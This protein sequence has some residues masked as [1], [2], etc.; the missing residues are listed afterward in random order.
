MRNLFSLF[1]IVFTI[2]V[3]TAQE[4]ETRQ[5]GNF[6]GIKV[7]G[8]M[9]VVLEK[10][11]KEEVL[12]ESKVVPL[13]RIITK[14]DKNGVLKIYKK[15]AN[16]Y[17]SIKYRE[18]VRS[19]GNINV[20]ITYKNLDNIT[21]S[22]SGFIIV[23]SKLT[24]ENFSISE[25]GSGKI[26]VKNVDL[27]QANITVSGSGKVEMKE[28]SIKEQRIRVSGSGKVSLLGVSAENSFSK[29]SGSGKIY[30]NVSQSF[31]GQVSGSGDILYSGNPAKIISKVSG[32][33][34]IRKTNK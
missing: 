6:K 14:I 34:K 3:S 1:I 30:V 10:G 2:F 25:S 5:L 9:R 24:G 27:N 28:G 13:D 7:S 8:S 21:Q 11:N 15:S 16:V 22:G 31:E 23:A 17:Q 26:L 18:F 19:Q 29:I 20:K 32:S 12:L 4:Q 33:G